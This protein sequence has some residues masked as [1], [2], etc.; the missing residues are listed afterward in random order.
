MKAERYGALLLIALGGLF[1]CE[2]AKLPSGEGGAPG[3]GFMPFWIGIGL[4]GFAIP[5]LIRPAGNQRLLDVVPHGSEGW[6]VGSASGGPCHLSP[7]SQAGRISVVHVRSLSISPPVLPAGLVVV[8]DRSFPDNGP[9]RILAFCG[10]FEMPLPRRAFFPGD[11]DSS[12]MRVIFG[13]MSFLTF[14]WVF[15]S[16]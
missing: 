13:W 3:A 10:F 11:G 12:L 1:V 7:Y 6:R 9:W 15:P 5:L 4:I 8:C 14:T 2:G 16:P